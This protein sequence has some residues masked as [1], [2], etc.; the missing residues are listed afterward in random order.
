MKELKKE[1]LQIT[2]MIHHFV[3]EHV[4]T[5]DICI[6][7]TAGRGNDTLF[8]CELVGQRGEVMAFDIQPQALEKTA[9][10]LAEHECMAEL[11]LDSHANMLDY[12]PEG[13]A[14]C[15]MFN[16]GYLPGGDHAIETK[17]KTSVEAIL[18]G[19]SILRKGGIMTLCLYDGSDV[20][21]EEKEAILAML[22]TL[23]PKTY[24]VITGCYYNRP[25]NPPM[26]VF[27]QKLEGKDSS[28]I[29]G[30]GLL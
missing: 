15:V 25:N 9:T 19:L 10:L 11:V 26:P 21:R 14:A 18:A 4:E 24:L 22:Q 8:L 30:F 16:F 1:D 28:C 20:Q 17:A 29:S 13:S 7:A 23:D 6:D 2:E 5:G 27:I 3:R 12:M